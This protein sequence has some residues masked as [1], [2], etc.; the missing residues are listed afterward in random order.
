MSLEKNIFFR[1]KR[2]LFVGFF[3]ENENL[4]LGFPKMKKNLLLDFPENEVERFPIRT[5][6][7]KCGESG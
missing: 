6:A 7:H 2:I 5:R 3:L 1:N 4:L